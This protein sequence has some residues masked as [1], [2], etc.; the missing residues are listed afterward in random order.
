V[1]TESPL[2]FARRELGEVKLVADHSWPHGGSTV[3]DIA[4]AVEAI[5]T[6]VWARDV[7]DPAF[8]QHGRDALTALTNFA[9]K[10][11]EPEDQSHESA[12]G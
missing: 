10:A 1:T 3:L 9:G 4:S 11:A 8:E 5:G 6:V 12:H 7:G 2:G